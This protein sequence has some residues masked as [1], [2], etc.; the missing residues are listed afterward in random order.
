VRRNAPDLSAMIR[1][2]GLIPQGVNRSYCGHRHD[3]VGH[4]VSSSSWVRYD[5][6][7]CTR[8]RPLLLTI[9]GKIGARL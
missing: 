2:D 4:R 3:R 6:G 1:L 9:I 8:S 7:R 5:G